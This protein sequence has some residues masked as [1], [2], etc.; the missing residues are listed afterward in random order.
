MHV[1]AAQCEDAAEACEVLRRSI[2]ELC[3]EDHRNDPAILE[4]WLAN[5]TPQNVSS[6]I[7]RPDNHVFVASDGTRILAVGAVTGGGE[8]TLN[9]VSPAAR[10]TGVSQ[11]VLRRLEAT[12][13]DLGNARCHLTSTVTARRFYVS[14][15]YVEQRPP[16]ETFGS[17]SYRMTKQLDASP[18]D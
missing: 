10:F 18:A 4:A 1:R 12:A 8:I 2:V 11:A 9:Y 15:G 5:K 3:L 14:A 6:W 16:I 17:T 13:R 7:A